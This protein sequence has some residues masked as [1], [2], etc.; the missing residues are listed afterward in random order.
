MIKVVR[1]KI[2]TYQIKITYN[3]KQRYAI[4]LKFRDKFL[5]SLTKLVLQAK[6]STSST[7]K[8]NLFLFCRKFSVF[9]V[10]VKS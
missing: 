5:T 10:V 3:L 1:Q 4:C 8:Q 7:I 6:A 2:S 9:I